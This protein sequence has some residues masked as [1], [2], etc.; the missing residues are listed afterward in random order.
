M[1]VFIILGN[2]KSVKQWPNRARGFMSRVFQAICN[3]TKTGGA[4]SFPT[5]SSS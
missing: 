3:C 5:K 4:L 2:G 1:N